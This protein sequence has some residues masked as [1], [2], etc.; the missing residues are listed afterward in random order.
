MPVSQ[1][2]LVRYKSH[3]F[4]RAYMSGVDRDEARIKAFGEVFTPKFLVDRI[5]DKMVESEPRVFS[6]PSKTV[7]DPTC[8]DGEFL[9]G[10]LF[11]RLENGISL[12]KALKT[13]YGID[14]QRSNVRECRKRLRCG[15]QDPRIKKILKENVIR[16]NT[17]KY[18]D[19]QMTIWER[20]NIETS[21]DDLSSRPRR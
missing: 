9:A 21:V 17:L 11:R 8:G 13:L 19:R 16:E 5:L 10:I 4:D 7:I 6:D 20:L 1:K 14:I 18:F 2:K 3:L 12:Y 15:S